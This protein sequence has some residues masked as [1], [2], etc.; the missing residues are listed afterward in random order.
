[1]IS[2]PPAASGIDTEYE[3]IIPRPDKA[4]L[5]AFTD[6]ESWQAAF[7]DRLTSVVVMLDHAGT[8]RTLTRETAAQLALA[9][10]QLSPDH[11]PTAT[12]AKTFTGS[13]HEQRL[14]I[15]LRLK[16]PPHPF[17]IWS[18]GLNPRS[19]ISDDHP[20]NVSQVAIVMPD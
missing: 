1:M 14:I 9:S 19:A 13:H 16:L 11:C 18:P 2:P 8:T 3:C 7:G 4:P 12:P 17:T 15:Q 6:I 10:L 5:T 20:L